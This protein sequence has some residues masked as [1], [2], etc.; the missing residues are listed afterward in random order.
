MRYYL[1][2]KCG[3]DKLSNTNISKLLFVKIE[4]SRTQLAISSGITVYCRPS[5]WGRW[6]VYF[7]PCGI[8]Y[9]AY[10]RDFISVGQRIC[11]SVCSWRQLSYKLATAVRETLMQ[12]GVAVGRADTSLRPSQQQSILQHTHVAV[13]GRASVQKSIWLVPTNRHQC[14]GQVASF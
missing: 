6:G 8:Q 13:C 10:D 5:E 9:E 1:G 12:S 11:T 14:T 4:Q 7:I 2:M 3:V